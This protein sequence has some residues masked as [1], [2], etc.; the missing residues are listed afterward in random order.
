MIQIPIYCQRVY[1]VQISNFDIDK[2]PKLISLVGWSVGEGDSLV[3]AV[4]QVTAAGEVEAEGF[5]GGGVF[6]KRCVE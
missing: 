1:E 4:K 6:Y 3:K 5:L 2:L